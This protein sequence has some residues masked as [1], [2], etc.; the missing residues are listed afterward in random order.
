MEGIREEEEQTASR[1]RTISKRIKELE[2]SLADSESEISHL[3]Q[4]LQQK[5]ITNSE[6]QK[7]L[8]SQTAQL[9]L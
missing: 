9:T 3:S 2:N 6:L 7:S 1:N 4:E 8:T 5:N